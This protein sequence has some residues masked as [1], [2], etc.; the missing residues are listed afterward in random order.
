MKIHDYIN[1]PKCLNDDNI[2]K[3]NKYEFIISKL[4]EN[5]NYMYLHMSE[6]FLEH[7][8][9][10]EVFKQVKNKIIL[11]CSGDIDFPPPKKPYSYHKYFNKNIL[12]DN[13]LHIDYYE[14]IHSNIVDV[15][16]QNN[17]YVV[18]FSVSINHPRIINFPLGIFPR[19]NYYHLKT[20]NKDILCYANFGIHYT[21]DGVSF[22]WYGNQR[23]EIVDIINDKEFILKENLIKSTG[24]YINNL[25]NFYNK[26][27][28]S[29]FALCPRG[30]GIDT[31]RL[32][33]CI[34]LGCIPIVE[35]YGGH[36]EYTDLPILF[37]NHHNEY[38][39]MNEEY[40]NNKYNEYLNKSFNYEKCTFDYWIKKII[41]LSTLI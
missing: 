9:I 40:L 19:F 7:N 1:L 3:I 28:R 18:T 38:K 36:E 21:H 27:S 15:I 4:V 26:I 14:K 25:D 41:D 39:E 30:C 2:L 10:V 16:E 37:I 8:D 22:P 33:D 35:K 5:Q 12:P 17:L 6:D 13:Y 24:R 23:G 20:N 34:V 32:W 29:K 11:I 31:Y